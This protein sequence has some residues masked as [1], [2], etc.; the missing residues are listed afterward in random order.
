[1]YLGPKIFRIH[2]ILFLACGVEAIGNDFSVCKYASSMKY[3]KIDVG[4][5]LHFVM[6]ASTPKEYS[7]GK[8]HADSIA[9]STPEILVIR[10]SKIALLHA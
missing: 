2:N 9:N 7:L 8:I 10:G 6:P 3:I 5:E 4:R 1:M